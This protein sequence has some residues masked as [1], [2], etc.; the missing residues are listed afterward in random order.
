M[1]ANLAKCMALLAL[2]SATGHASSIIWGSAVFS[3]LLDSHGNA[4]VQNTY[5]FELGV[6]D[7][8]FNATTTPLSEWFT[9]WTMVDSAAYSQNNGYFAATL[10]TEN[11]APSLVGKDAYLWIRNSPTIEY[12][13]GEWLLVRDSNWILPPAHSP[14]SINACCD[15]T[16]PLQWSVSDLG[17]TDV[18]LYGYQNN[19]Y[20]KPVGTG[21][22]STPTPTTY[23]QTA[24]YSVVPE[25][26][27]AVMM[28]VLGVLTLLDRRRSWR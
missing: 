10:L 5:Q 15:N 8:A 4:L 27:S 2:L 1:K 20:Q 14:S 28:L 21:G 23:L 13:S 22:V 6:F 25:P 19:S 26:Y 9:H 17:A 18:P 12:Q 16:P 3:D 7:A 11:I 24:S